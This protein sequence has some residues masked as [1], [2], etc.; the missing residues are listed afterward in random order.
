MSSSI[1]IY[2]ESQTCN[3]KGRLHLQTAFYYSIVQSS[4]TVPAA[5]P[6]IPAR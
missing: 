1:S 2:S 4:F 6:A 5:D 3:R